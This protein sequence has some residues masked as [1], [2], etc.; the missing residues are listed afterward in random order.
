VDKWHN[1]DRNETIL[2]IENI[3]DSTSGSVDRLSWNIQYLIFM[4]SLHAVNSFFKMCHLWNFVG[5]FTNNFCTNTQL[6]SILVKRD[7]WIRESTPKLEYFCGLFH[8]TVSIYTTEVSNRITDGWIRMDKEG[9]GCGLTGALFK[10]S[11]ER[12]RKAMK[13]VCQDSRCPT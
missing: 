10:I 6:W 11:V 3:H 8:E 2:S 4:R 7:S 12:L 5:R 1:R 9:S 13:T